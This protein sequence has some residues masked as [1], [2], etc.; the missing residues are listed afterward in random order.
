M[1]I[2]TNHQRSRT[3]RAERIERKSHKNT[4]GRRNERE[5]NATA[6]APKTRY[7]YTKA[8]E[9]IKNTPKATKTQYK[10]KLSLSGHNERESNTAK[11]QSTAHNAPKI[12]YINR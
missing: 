7:I 1:A 3:K 4:S 6:K 12:A 9:P 5:Q 2:F 10:Q 11:A 8:L